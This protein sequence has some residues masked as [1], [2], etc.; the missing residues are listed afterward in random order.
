M[1]TSGILLVISGPSAGAG[2]D[3][4]LK[5]LLDS[6]DGWHNPPSTTTRGIRKGETAGK[7]MSFVSHEE[8]MTLQEQGKFLETDHHADHWYGTLREPV[9]T[10][11]RAGK[12]VVLRVDVNGALKIKK[13]MPEAIT[14]FLT[15]GSDEALERRIRNRATEDEETIQKR[16][17]LAKKEFLLAG[18]F[19][20]I[21]VNPDGHPEQAL[22]EIQK[23]AKRQI[24]TL[25]R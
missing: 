8:F 2:K 11:L 19:D 23:L 4:M 1:A 9:E 14:I 10:L 15:A 3:T 22:K 17:T 6:D 18:Q 24:G 21:V 12:N 5:M 16:L 7:Q 20:H 25:D 13:K